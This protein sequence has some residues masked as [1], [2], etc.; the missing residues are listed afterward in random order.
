MSAQRRAILALPVLFLVALQA[1]AQE[2]LPIIDMHLHAIAADEEGP[3]PVAICSPIDPFPT[4]DPAQP[5]STT[6]MRMV[7]QPPCQD[8]VWSPK[9]DEELMTQTIG[10]MK[11]R[12][13][14]GVLSGTPDRVA[15]WMKAAPGRFYPGFQLR[16]GRDTASPD[17]TAR[18]RSRKSSCGIRSYG[19]TSC[20]PASPCWTTFLPSSTRTHRSTWTSASSS[21]SSPGRRSTVIF[22]ASWKPASPNA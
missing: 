17:C 14:F 11:R 10:V 5:Y 21:S 7:K 13:I 2:P 12:N 6:F 8:P 15:T 18:S 16:L 19:S 9:T 1:Q 4:W 20:M 22:A 3:P